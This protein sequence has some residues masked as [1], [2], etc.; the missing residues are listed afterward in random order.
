MAESMDVVYRDSGL[1]E[2]SSSGGLKR[3]HSVLRSSLDAEERRS[4]AS[5]GAS[6]A[7]GG[8]RCAS[9]GESACEAD[10]ACLVDDA[11]ETDGSDWAVWTERPPRHF[12]DA[13]ATSSWGALV[14]DAL[15]PVPPPPPPPTPAT[16]KHRLRASLLGTPDARFRDALF[17]KAR[18][19][20]LSVEPGDSAPAARVVRGASTSNVF[21][22]RHRAHF[23]NRAPRRASRA[24]ASTPPPP[25][26]AA[27]GIPKPRPP[28]W[29]ST[30]S[31]F[32]EPAPAPEQRAAARAVDLE[33]K[34]RGSAVVRYLSNLPSDPMLAIHAI[35]GCAR[36]HDKKPPA[37]PGEAPDHLFLEEMV[38]EDAN[39]ATLYFPHA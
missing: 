12:A 3:T 30:W 38:S 26:P 6:D 17:C 13:L 1:R 21:T 33:K 24:A 32:T 8:S 25:P 28:H 11:G 2:R 22:K 20:D 23:Q 5:S 29:S 7:S 34:G 27:N 14:G 10:R 37:P 31:W 15:A 35:V 19:V 18:A 16:L 9:M 39:L 36:P 4:R